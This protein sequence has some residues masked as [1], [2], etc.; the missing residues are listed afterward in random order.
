MIKFNSLYENILNK[1]DKIATFNKKNKEK[2]L[3]FNLSRLI[4]F[5]KSQIRLIISEI[6][7]SYSKEN[8]KPIK[9]GGIEFELYKKIV[10]LFSQ[11]IIASVK[12]SYFEQEHRETASYI[13]DLYKKNKRINFSDFMAKVKKNKNIIYTFTNILDSKFI[14]KEIEDKFEII[15][16]I[17]SEKVINGILKDFKNSKSKEYILF[18]FEENK[19][20][21]L[22]E[23]TILI[24]NFK[25]EENNLNKKII[26]HLNKD[27]S[28]KEKN[29]F[30]I[31]LDDD[32]DKYFIDNLND[33]QNKF[34]EI[35]DK[36][37][38][39][40]LFFS[41]FTKGEIDNFVFNKMKDIFSSFNYDIKNIKEQ[42][43][44]IDYVKN[45]LS[46]IKKIKIKNE[47]IFN[48]IKNKALNLIFQNKNNK[49][50]DLKHLN[51][52]IL[53]MLTYSK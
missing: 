8:D 39:R 32:Y 20:K 34:E 2:N 22:N 53:K 12:Y 35:L 52:T 42:N 49:E 48:L 18:K 28:E 44:K 15:N 41:M 24:N 21:K 47:N 17:E 46:I 19:A 30:S 7:K 4:I 31:N 16:E 50:K 40:D 14:A 25:L 51:S 37:N 43:E 5:T 27:I 3:R 23:L 1:L 10:P 29:E 45:V 9:E 38:V 36:K 26:Y 33:D 6:I 11:D 13:Y